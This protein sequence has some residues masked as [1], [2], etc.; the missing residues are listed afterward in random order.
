MFCLTV[1][2]ADAAPVIYKAIFTLD[3]GSIRASHGFV[4]FFDDIKVSIG[5][6]S[7]IDNLS[8][9]GEPIS[10][11]GGPRVADY[12]F[13]KS[14]VSQTQ[15]YPLSSYRDATGE[16]QAVGTGGL[17]YFDPGGTHYSG[18]GSWELRA[19]PV[20]ASLPLLLIGLFGLVAA[21]RRWKGLFFPFQ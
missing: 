4:V 6:D 7:P 1:S 16:S 13:S 21:V 10:V 18:S 12:F 19:V 11:I 9:R 20:L 2:A 14:R 17:Q 3:D 15:R 8:F 5:S